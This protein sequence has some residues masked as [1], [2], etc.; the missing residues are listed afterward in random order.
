MGQADLQYKRGTVGCNSRRRIAPVCSGRGVGVMPNYRRV[1]IPGG[2][3]F[4]TVNL[5]DRRRRLL[6]E[7]IAALRDAVRWT[8][9]RW[10]F[11]IDAWVVM[12]DHLRAIWSLPPGDTDFPMRW[13]HIKMRFS[14]ALPN[15]EAS[16]TSRRAR[17][18]RGIWQ[19]RYWEHVIRDE[20]DFH[21]HLA[22][23]WL[24]PVKHGLVAEIDDW[25][26]SS[27]HRDRPDR[28]NMTRFQAALDFH[29]QSAIPIGFGERE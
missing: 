3:W 16:T 19:R 18:E 21:A 6:V 22:Y 13:R 27:Y 1:F 10:P 9:D 15:T 20:H 24:N 28:D 23:C 26:F 29:A 14:K 2:C 7:R 5:F 11:E 8:R 17:S 12:P 4:F 25:P